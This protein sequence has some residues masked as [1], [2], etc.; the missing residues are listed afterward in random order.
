MEASESNGVAALTPGKSPE[1]AWNGT[2]RW[3]RT[4]GQCNLCPAGGGSALWATLGHTS[5]PFHA[6]FP[7]PSLHVPAYDQV[8]VPSPVYD[9]VHD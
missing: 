6:S 7:P 3:E 9:Q 2:L 8:H 1:S 5:H 4:D